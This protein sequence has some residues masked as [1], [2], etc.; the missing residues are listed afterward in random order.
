MNFYTDDSP[1]I[2]IQPVSGFMIGGV[3]LWQSGAAT[4]SL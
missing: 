4:T 2:K 1:G 3:L